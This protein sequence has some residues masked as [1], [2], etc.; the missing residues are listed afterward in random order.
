MY[1]EGTRLSNI[2]AS[3]AHESSTQVACMYELRE[4]QPKSDVPFS[5][6]FILIVFRVLR[7]NK[8]KNLH[9]DRLIKTPGP[10]S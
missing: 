2:F 4:V 5:N 7:R 8:S 1:R 10:V 9:N 6:G 3:L